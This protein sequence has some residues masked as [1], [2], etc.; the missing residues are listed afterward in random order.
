MMSCLQAKEYLN[1]YYDG[2]CP[3]E[4]RD[5]LTGHLTSCRACQKKLDE[6]IFLSTRIFSHRSVQAPPF[7]WTKVLAGIEAQEASRSA[8]WWVQWRWMSRLTMAAA[9]LASVGSVYLFNQSTLSLERALEGGSN[10]HAIQEARAATDPGASIA[11]VLG[12]DT[13]E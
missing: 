8:P 3:P 12:G 4:R 7:L 11:L 6:L 2:Q 5:E 13:W 10:Q 9:V 1:D